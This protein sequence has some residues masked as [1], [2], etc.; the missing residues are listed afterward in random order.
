[1]SL[2]DRLLALFREP[3]FTPANEYELAG[4]LGLNKKQRASLAHEVR[5]LLR[6]GA[7]VRSGNGRIAPRGAQPE[8]TR[9]V[10]V[11]KI[12]TPTRRGAAMPAPAEANRHRATP[13]AVGRQ[14]V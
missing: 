4:R 9:T 5:L 11:R 12:F 1:M 7:L 8:R 3:G 2:R 10:E 6:D 13:Q 14:A